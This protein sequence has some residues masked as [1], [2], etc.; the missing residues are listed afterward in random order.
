M[1]S[2]FNDTIQKL[3]VNFR[4]YLIPHPN[5]GYA[6][7]K[8]NH[9]VF[10]A[11]VKDLPSIL[12]RKLK[13][14]KLSNLEHIKIKGSTGDGRVGESFWIAFLDERVT[15]TTT[16]GIYIVLLFDKNIDNVYLA[17]GSGTEKSKLR[18]IRS[19]TEIRRNHF[20]TLIND[21]NLVSNFNTKEIY[22]GDKER[23][24]K[25]AASVCISKQYKVD[26]LNLNILSKDIAILNDLYYKYLFEVYMAEDLDVTQ[27]S[28][29]NIRKKR[30]INK[31][32]YKRLREERD[33]RNKYIGDQAEEYIYNLEKERLKNSGLIE[34]AN[35]VE[36][37]ALKQDG[38]GYDIKSFFVDGSEKYIEVK[39][40]S[41]SLDEFSFYLSSREKETAEYYRGSFVL[42]LVQNVGSENVKIFDEIA[43]PIGKLNENLVPIAYKGVLKHL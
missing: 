14:E 3:V 43:N 1:F 22:L 8:K 30:G 27:S 33:N 32:K 16:E 9:P 13:N 2:V 12:E 25:Y 24:K 35:E 29:S 10:E 5:L 28:N 37:V 23:A 19:Y 18:E 20:S 31:D 7:T 15:T 38:L 41:L 36:W 17:I 21:N 11:I 34:L 6:V 40:S 39:G 4:D 42:A 26:Q